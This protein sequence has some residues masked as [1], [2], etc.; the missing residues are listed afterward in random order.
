MRTNMN[1]LSACSSGNIAPASFN[2]SMIDCQVT[3]DSSTGVHLVSLARTL[4]YSPS[5]V[6]TITFH[7]MYLHLGVASVVPMGS[8]DSPSYLAS[9]NVQ[10]IWVSRGMSLEAKHF[11]TSIQSVVVLSD[12]GLTPS[13]CAVAADGCWSFPTLSGSRS[14]SPSLSPSFEVAAE[15]NWRRHMELDDSARSDDEFDD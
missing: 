13:E 6:Y 4:P 11:G 14:P 9:I 1:F 10:C 15:R 3:L 7:A 5:Y 8:L 2:C 12:G